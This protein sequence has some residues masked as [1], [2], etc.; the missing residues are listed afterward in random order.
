M[1]CTVVRLGSR[2]L[3]AWRNELG[4]RIN[5]IGRKSR[6]AL[7]SGVGKGPVDAS[8]I[9]LGSN[10]RQ[11]ATALPALS[12][13]AFKGPDTAYTLSNHASNQAYSS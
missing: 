1:S 4:S 7:G 10:S 3:A 2:W 8:R 13:F 9:G 6:G 12:L 5:A 11:K